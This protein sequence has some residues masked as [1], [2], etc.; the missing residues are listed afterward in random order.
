MGK[1][2]SS[3]VD[4]ILRG[5]VDPHIHSG[6]CLINRSL[7]HVEAT[8]E[9]MNAGMRAIVLKDHHAPTTSVANVIQQEIVGDRDFN[10]YGSVALNNASGGL[11]PSVVELNAKL[12]AKVVWMPTLSAAYHRS[13]HK[14]ISAVAQKTLPKTS[15]KLM[16]DDDMTILDGN[17]KLKPE[18]KEIIKIIASEDMVLANGHISRFETDALIDEAKV[19][20]VKKIVIDHPELHLKMSLDEMKEYTDA[21]VYLEHVL[22][23]IYSNKSSHEYIYEMVKKTG[24][25]NVIIASDL[26]QVGRPRPVAAM[27]LF[28]EAMLE[29]GLTEQEI[30]TILVDNPSKLLSI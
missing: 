26:G 23:I 9:A 29:L 16:Y 11:N 27:R 24:V 18:V 1:I 10:V 15:K 7:T 17:K 20:G 21:G 30:R 5:A 3:I 14:S 12:G 28:V 19:Q 22:A 13:Y 25:E 8:K 2:D 6:P 4:R